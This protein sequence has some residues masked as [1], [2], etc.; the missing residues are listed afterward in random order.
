MWLSELTLLPVYTASSVSKSLPTV[1]TVTAMFD[2]A[3]QRYQTERPPV[4][5][6]WL[7][8][9]DSLLAHIVVPVRLPGTAEIIWAFENGSLAGAEQPPGIVM[10]ICVTLLPSLDSST[11]SFGSA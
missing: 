9:P 1:V 5:P 10:G 11:K 2:G 4:S 6:A 7:G 8:S 3:V